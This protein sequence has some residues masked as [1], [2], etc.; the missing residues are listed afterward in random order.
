[1]GA[2]FSVREA[3]PIAMSDEDQSKSAPALGPRSWR[4]SGQQLRGM[5]A[6]II[7]EGVRNGLL[8]S[9]TG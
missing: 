6:E 1:L 5:Y 2:P 3:L 4:Q 8:R 7:A 9:G